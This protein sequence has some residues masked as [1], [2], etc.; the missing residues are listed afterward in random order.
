M[1][2]SDIANAAGSFAAD[3]DAGE[4]GIC[5]SAIA[6]DHVLRGAK[7]RKS[8]R[9]A[10]GLQRNAIVAGGDVAS[11]Y[12]DM[13]ARIDVDAVTIAA[14]AADGEIFYGNIFAVG[15]MKSPH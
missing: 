4:N 7:Q 8:F 3:S 10:A 9:A 12:D 2:N 13:L 5:E 15:R 6:D 11:V 1:L 14:D